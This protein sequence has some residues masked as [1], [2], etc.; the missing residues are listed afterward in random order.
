MP[1]PLQLRRA[2]LSLATLVACVVLALYY[3]RLEAAL[4]HLV[5]LTGWALDQAGFSARQV[6]SFLAAAFLLPGVAWWWIQRR[7]NKSDD[8]HLET[9][10]PA[11][12][13]ETAD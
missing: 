2:A 3:P 8:H 10:Q 5:Y 6:A 9:S 12:E 1:R 13:A 7:L 11:V 4:P